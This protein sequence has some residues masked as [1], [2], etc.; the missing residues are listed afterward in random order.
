MLITHVTRCLQY[1]LNVAL[2]SI[3]GQRCRRGGG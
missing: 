1:A 2:L 3:F